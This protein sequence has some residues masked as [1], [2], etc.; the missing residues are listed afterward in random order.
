MTGAGLEEVQ[1]ATTTTHFSQPAPSSPSLK[2]YWLSGM[3]CW[4][5]WN[6]E[7]AGRTLRRYR[8]GEGGVMTLT[9]AECALIVAEASSFLSDAW[10]H[11]DP[12]GTEHF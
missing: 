9:K 5:R 10:G 11:V 4:Q 2:P 1:V 12:D 3:I 7:L 6:G 8:Q